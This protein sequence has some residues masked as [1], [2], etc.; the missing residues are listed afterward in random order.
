VLPAKL[1]GGTGRD[2]SHQLTRGHSVDGGVRACSGGFSGYD[3]H[4]FG[5][6][7]KMGRGCSW[8]GLHGVLGVAGPER[9]VPGADTGTGA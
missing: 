6:V 3:F 1:A 7:E 8:C 9:N 2:C 4:G 5:L